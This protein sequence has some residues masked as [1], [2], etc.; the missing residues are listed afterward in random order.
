MAS[1]WDLTSVWDHLLF[2]SAQWVNLEVD[3][4]VNLAV[5]WQL[6][7]QSG[8]GY[9]AWVTIQIQH[10]VYPEQNFQQV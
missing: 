9:A 10:A 8:S 1:V 7:Q 4:E 2:A 3:L 6:L 5:T